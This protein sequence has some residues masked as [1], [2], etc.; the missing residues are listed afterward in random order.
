M[1]TSRASRNGFTAA[2]DLERWIAVEPVASRVF[3]G[4]SGSPRPEFAEIDR[5]L[6]HRGLDAMDFARVLTRVLNLEEDGARGRGK[7]HG[8]VLVMARLRQYQPIDD[9]TYAG[10]VKVLAMPTE[11][12]HEHVA[13]ILNGTRMSKMPK[14]QPIPSW[15]G[16]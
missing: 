9:G 10:V 2:D 4:T 16:R 14:L 12:I 11:L 3:D 6:E 13:S 15:N 7:C 5:I 8:A 1:P